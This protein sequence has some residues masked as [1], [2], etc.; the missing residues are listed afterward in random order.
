MAFILKA[1]EVTVCG[2]SPVRYEAPSPGKA[3][4]KAFRDFTECRNRTFR[5]FLAESTIHRI[6][7]PPRF[8]EPVLVSG[9]PAY[10]CL[11]LHG[12]YVRFARDDS[13]VVLFSHPLDIAPRPAPLGV[14]A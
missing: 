9:A 6:P 4:A 14:P 5:E 7:D 1:Y 13:D 2:Y 11:D 12:Q 8:G 10:L 3:R